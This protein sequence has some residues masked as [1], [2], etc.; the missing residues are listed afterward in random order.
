MAKKKKGART[1]AMRALDAQ[2]IAYVAHTYP[3]ERHSAAEVAAL[4]G[5]PEEQVFK[6]LVVLPTE[7]RHQPLLAILAGN[8]EL[9]LKRLA[10][11]AGIKRL[12]MAA[13]KEA[14]QLT[15]LQ[16]GGI[17]AL[18]LLDKGWPVF[19]DATAQ[20]WPD[21]AVSAGQRGINLQLAVRDLIA[22]TEAR[23]ADISRPPAV[24][25]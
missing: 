12:R 3:S 17:S 25:P 19:L 18:A 9:D 21:I 1:N 5:L 20:D 11:V 15:R 2:G 22:V 7:G 16:V 13:H 8:R 14:E 10:A 4:I 24:A 23:I 6:T